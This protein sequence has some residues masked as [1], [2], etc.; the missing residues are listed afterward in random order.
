[1]ELARC[2][3]AFAAGLTLLVGSMPLSASAQGTFPSRTVTIVVPYAAGGGTD[4]VARTLAKALSAHWNQSVIVENRTGADGWI[5]TQW[6]LNQPADGHT[7]LVQLN[8]LMLWR[9][10]MP[11]NK[12]DVLQDMRVITKIQNSP[13][14][15]TVKG[16]TKATSLRDFLAAC[17]AAAKP[18]SIAGATVS[19]NLV[20]Q[21]LMDLG[22]LSDAPSVPYKGTAPMITDLLGGH[23][24]VALISAS[25]AVPMT[26]EGKVKSFAVGTDTRYKR[27]PDAPTFVEAGYPIHATTWYGLMVK[28]GVGDA[29][30]NAIVEGIQKVS[31]QPEVLEAIENQGGIPVFDSPAAFEAD[32]RRESAALVPLAEK[33][34]VKSEKQGK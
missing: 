22:G 15:A 6:A 13:M 16:D 24:D 28:R 20:G 11:E 12:F 32:I 31:K 19:A 10:S 23:I 3:T 8:S 14:V 33:Y 9:W 17:K 4:A 18:C 2:A 27:L 1:L 26:T 25:L 5:G 29:A 7:I 21:Q 34:L 30:F